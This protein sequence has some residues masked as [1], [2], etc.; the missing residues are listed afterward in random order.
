VDKQYL[1]QNFLGFFRR[2]YARVAR[3]HLEAGWVP[4]D[5]R[6]DEFESAI[7]A[8]CEPFFDRPLKE[9]SFG[10]ALVRLFQTSRRFNV[11]I[12]PQLIML[13]K[14][15]L[16][17]EG[18]GRQLDPELDLWTTA[19][20]F[21]ENW[22]R[23]QIGLKGLLRALRNEAP[24][25]ATML[26]QLPRLVHRA[27]AGDR[28]ERIEQMLADLLAVERRRNRL[29]GLAVALLALALAWAAFLT[30]V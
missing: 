27:L 26:P 11:Q 5:T 24:R 19:K 10:R 18:L 4:A 2:D 7:R 29:I 21:L 23:E 6:M 16:N 3:A 13:Q 1:A 12:Q 25:W 15:L 20:P 30:A 22:M 8:V 28:V 17:I 14:T 9:I